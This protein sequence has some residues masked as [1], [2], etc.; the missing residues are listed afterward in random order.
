VLLGATTY[1]NSLES[2]SFTATSFQ[3]SSS[4]GT[5][6]LQFSVTNPSG[7]ALIQ[8][9]AYLD[10]MDMGECNPGPVPWALQ[11]NQTATCVITNPYPSPISCS[12]LPVLADYALRLNAYFGNTKTVNNFYSVSR[13]QVGCT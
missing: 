9:N 2:V 3:F 13:E 8:V 12:N 6:S 7:P 5:I 1:Q 10:G 11:T 4:G